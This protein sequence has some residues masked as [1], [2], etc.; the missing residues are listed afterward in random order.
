MD[1][2]ARRARRQVGLI[3]IGGALLVLA[4]LVADARRPADRAI[5]KIAGADSVVYYAVARSMLF[6]HDVDLR[7]EIEAL[8]PE[9]GTYL[10]PVPASGLPAIVYPIGFS[11]LQ[12]PWIA[13]GSAFDW[14][15]GAPVT[16]YS[17]ACLRAYYLGIL[18][19]L[20]LGLSALFLWL[21]EVGRSLGVDGPRGDI[22]ALACTAAVWPSTTLG[23]YT[24]SA[25]SHVA[26]FAATSCFL[27]TWWRARDSVS[28]W[29]WAPVG[30]AAGV[31]VLCRWQEALLLIVPAVWDARYWLRPASARERS[32][33]A[34]WLRSRAV[35]AAVFVAALVPQFVV[36]KTIYGAWLTI[37][38]GEGFLSFPPPFVLETLFSSQNGWFAWTPV[39]AIGVAGLVVGW[40][41]CP[42]LFG[43]LLAGLAAELV[44]V[45]GVLTWHGHWFGLRY[46]TSVTPLV[47]A[48][49]LAIACTAGRRGVVL[50]GAG[51]L[52]CSAYTLVFAVQFRLDL[53]PKQARLTADELLWDKLH[54][55]RAV[56]R[57][58][59]AI[60]A[61]RALNDGDARRALDLAERAERELGTSDTLLTVRER[62][63]VALDDA[64]TSARV[65]KD[66]RD[67]E[68]RRLF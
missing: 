14:L 49:L 32:A 19:W 68:A 65:A 29:S 66:R 37:P 15:S 1:D 63:A 25:M 12:M 4:V 17:A 27:W 44:L 10:D 51:V 26:A 43:G 56:E 52:A 40:R 39:T 53:I 8:H 48:G 7:N 2:A 33:P 23:Y 3:W 60:A 28:A 35:S 21:R 45:S 46:L 57:Q 41:Y 22:T 47:A 61:S 50:L 62:A 59:E 34:A 38:Q 58:R 20:C 6:D 18:T 24:F 13:L 11:L 9:A 16:G 30:A 42:L 31:M 67:Y 36:W 55:S 54:L 64:A 5:V